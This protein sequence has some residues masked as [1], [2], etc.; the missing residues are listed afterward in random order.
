M[1]GDPLT[2][3]IHLTSTRYNNASTASECLRPVARQHDGSLL[4]VATSGGHVMQLAELADRFAGFH[5]RLWVTFDS[6]QGRSLL[7]G[8]RV[9]FIPEIR[10]RDLFGILRTLPQVRR[11]IAAEWP[12]AAV[13]STGSA[14]ALAFLPYAAMRG[15]PT[16]YIESAARTRKPSLT[17][18]VLAACPRTRLYRQYE[19][20]AAGRWVFGGSVFDGY[21][22]VE[23][24]RRT[25][26]KVVVT[27]G[28]SYGFDR[29]VRRLAALIPR[30]LADVVWQIGDTSADG[31]EITA[32]RF[33]SAPALRDAMASADLVIAHAGCGSALSAL[34]T[35]KC[36]VLVPR[37]PQHG[38]VVDDHQIELAAWLDERKLAVS[39]L[40]EDLTLADLQLAASRAVTRSVPLP[41]FRLS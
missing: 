13:I 36:P 27:L 33:L 18:R 41:P 35:G 6:E 4:L 11:L 10:E 19:H 21:R 28:M 23:I 17:G 14:I 20:C 2:R 3:P 24:G 9:V 40:A 22:S 37:D 12:V 5:K 32:Q 29:L 39:R 30:D 7:A 31:L 1:I 25:I 26:R 16:H 38:E 8:E 34:K 15:I